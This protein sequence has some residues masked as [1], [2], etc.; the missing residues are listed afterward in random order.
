MSLKT[1]TIDFSI[2]IPAYREEKRI[3]STLEELAIYLNTNS[4]LKKLNVEVLVVAA[5]SPD[6]TDTVVISKKTKFKNLSL[7][8][9]GAK[10]G[11]GRDVQYGMLR[12]KGDAILFMDADMATPVKYVEQ[13]YRSYFNGSDVVVATRNLKKHHPSRLRR[14]ISNGGNLL[15]RILGGLW[16]ED[17]QCG[18]KLF[19]AQASKAC[20]SNMTIMGWGFDMEILAIAKING[21]KI[22]TYRINDWVSVPEGSFLD[23]ALQSS[24]KSLHELTIIFIKRISGSYKIKPEVANHNK[25]A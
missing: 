20:F 25:H 12:A 6:Y 5:D 11:K 4:T 13:F 8:K 19:S 7:L 9:P 15:F 1:R 14:S 18:F 17:S 10:V 24:A 21:Y 16:I 3:G 22:E 2:V 23:G